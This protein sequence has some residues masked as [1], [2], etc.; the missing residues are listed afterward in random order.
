M[1]LDIVEAIRSFN[2]GRDPERLAM[3]YRKLRESPF[4]FLR[5]TCHLFYA[6]LPKEKVLAAG[7][8]AWISGDL[9]FENFGTYKGANRLV[10]YDINDFDEAVLAPVTWE[11]A[12]LLAS[13]LVAREALHLEPAGATR[14]CQ[15][16]IDAYA[17]ALVTGKAGWIDRDTAT[18]PVQRL[19]QG[20]R[21]RKRAQFLDRRT[22]LKGRTRSIRCDG[23]HALE[24]TQEQKRHAIGLVDKHASGVD[25]PEFFK[26]L[27]VARRIA[28][29]GSL[30]VERYVVLVEG[31][32]FPAG[33]YLLDLKLASPSS[34]EERVKVKQPRWKPRAR[35]VVALQ[36]WLQAVSPAFLSHV[37]AGKSSYVLREL[38]P[39]EDRVAVAEQRVS[40]GEIESVLRQMGQLAAWAQLRSSGREGSAIA[41]ELIAFGAASDKWSGG[42]M[43]AAHLCAERVARDWQTYCAAYDK[44]AFRPRPA[45]QASIRA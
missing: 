42:L 31:K 38:Q 10:Y 5:G 37:V 22:T 11:L 9:H 20:L 21:E 40:A 28:G 43:K 13:I 30:G 39:S 45:R 7:P 12:R 1:A 29:T 26:V 44:G 19:L 3:K 8:V 25:R 17:Q 4:L 6:R 27:D 14:L 33:N 23:K 15:S 36:Q 32:G 34:L 16:V 41:D 24:A 2:A 18:G 35:R